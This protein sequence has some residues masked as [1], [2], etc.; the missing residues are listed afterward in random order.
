MS[1]R[2]L[3]A[4]ALLLGVLAAAVDIPNRKSVDVQELAAMVEREEDHVTALELAQWIRERKQGLRVIDLRSAKAFDE[5]H[6][7]GAERI[8]LQTLTRTQFGPHETLVLCSDGGAHAAQ[9]W[10]FL[11]MRGHRQVY[12]LR[13]GVNE[14][15]DQVVNAKKPTELTRYFGRR[16]C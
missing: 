8:A 10:V 2:V 5:F 3:A 13:G 15:I 4:L 11:R 12:F 1:R 6:I 14:W 16:T 9:A 7:P